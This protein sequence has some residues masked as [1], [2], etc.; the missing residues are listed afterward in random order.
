MCVVCEL[1]LNK[2]VTKRTLYKWNRKVYNFLGLT[3]STQ[4]NSLETD[5]NCC[6]YQYFILTLFYC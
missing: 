1:H 6:M 3:F 2:T 4:Y 5:L